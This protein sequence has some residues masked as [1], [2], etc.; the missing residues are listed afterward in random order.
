M[1]RNT[2]IGRIWKTIENLR[3]KREH[4]LLRNEDP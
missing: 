2:I 3:T 4:D 1:E